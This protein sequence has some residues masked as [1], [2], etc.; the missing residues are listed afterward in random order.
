M[1]GN[2]EGGSAPKKCIRLYQGWVAWLWLAFIMFAGFLG[3]LA[4]E[5]L[6]QTADAVCAEVKIVIE[7]KFSMER[8][9]FDAKMVVTNGLA[10][11]KL[12][13]VS[14]EL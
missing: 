1:R 6:A 9:A 8:Q 2:Q 12:E 10:D 14:I 5:A 7:Q 11:Q 4:R 3:P 13:N